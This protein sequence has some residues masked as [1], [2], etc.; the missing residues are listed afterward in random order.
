MLGT[1]LPQAT[2]LS[3]DSPALRAYKVSGNCWVKRCLLNKYLS[4]GLNAQQGRLLGG[5]G[6][7]RMQKS[8]DHIQ[9]KTSLRAC[10]SGS[11]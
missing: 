3:E 7:E 11:V 8:S 9:S 4:G 10:C 1:E 2:R 5:G 6:L